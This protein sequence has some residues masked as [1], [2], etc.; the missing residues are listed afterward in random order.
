MLIRE[1]AAV[2]DFLNKGE[3]KKNIEKK[4]SKV[5]SNGWREHENF[6]VNLLGPEEFRSTF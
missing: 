2:C 6:W 5:M 1:S 3:K 4:K